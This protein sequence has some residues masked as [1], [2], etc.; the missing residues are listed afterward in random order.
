MLSSDE[1]KICNLII[2]NNHDEAMRL[3]NTTVAPKNTDSSVLN[4]SNI[5]VATQHAQIPSSI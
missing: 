3:I 1:R 5:T 2:A 4:L